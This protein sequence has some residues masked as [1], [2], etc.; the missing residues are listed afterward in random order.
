MKNKLLIFILFLPLLSKAYYQKEWKQA[1]VKEGITV[2]NRETEG[3]TLKEFKG[4]MIVTATLSSIVTTIDDIANFP[5]WGYHCKEARILKDEGITQYIYIVIG[6]VWPVQNR[7]MI[8]KCQISQNPQNKEV[9]ITLFG[10][11]DYIPQRKD[12]VRMPSASGVFIL[13]PMGKNQIKII[14][15][16]KANAGGAIPIWMS[17]M[18]EVDSPFYALKNLRE[19]IKKDIYRNAQFKGIA[20]N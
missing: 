17:N 8:Y 9:T 3:T 1:F 16:L 7:D 5:N 20:D 14:Y 13:T 2:Y 15:Q 10:V 4:E 6:A 11:P 12:I 19:E 18:I